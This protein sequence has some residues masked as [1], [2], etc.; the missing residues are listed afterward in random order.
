MDNSFTS[1]QNI[2]NIYN[3]IN[4]YFVK[5]YNYNLDDTPKYTKIVKK[6][7]KTIFN[8]IKNKKE[9][10][11]TLINDFNDIVLDKS[12]GYLLKDINSNKTKNNNYDIKSS[13]SNLIESI[14]LEPKKNN[15]TKSKKIKILDSQNQKNDSTNS[16]NF[17]NNLDNFNIQI[18][19]A[20][21]KIKDNFNKIIED[22]DNNFKKD[23]TSEFLLNRCTAKDEA[24]GLYKSGEEAN[25]NAF[26][27]LLENKLETNKLN[28]STE[29][30]YSNTNI[31]DLLTSVI[32]KQNDNSKANEL[33]SYEGE[34][35]L[36]NLLPTLGDEAPVQPLIYQ[37]SGQGT[38]RIDKKI[39]SI[40]SGTKTG[41]NNELDT[42]TNN[43]TNNWYQFRV[44]LQ[45]SIK[46]D[47]LCDVY[48]RNITVIGIT[49]NTN[50]NY[51]VIDIDE[52]NIRNYSNNPEMRNKITVLNTI[53]TGA[54]TSVL[55]VNF[56][57]EAN[58]ITTI[59]PSK[60]AQ[61]NVSVTNQ[62]NKHADTGAEKT[63]HVIAGGTE[64]ANRIIFELEFKTRGERDEMI[65][66][67]SMY[68]S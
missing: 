35:Y 67:K 45:D 66:E 52:F 13:N 8:T 63:F 23:S 62:D 33:E 5:N 18:K 64:I 43:G 14:T 41:G 68:S 65:Y 27:K 39:I 50:C 37:N 25:K 6:I 60:V 2:E 1:K 51:I 49:S 11:N 30:V 26:E 58:Y 47:K 38:E 9:Y 20:N 34:E 28:E 61:L 48:L 24:D 36:P 57:S 55:N 16:G 46:I 44:D 53:T 12:I 40:D 31:S 56:A 15:K 4:A 54:A 17:I 59:N 42:V 29:S 32:F 19:Q 10:Q 7:S 3:N 21:K 22:N